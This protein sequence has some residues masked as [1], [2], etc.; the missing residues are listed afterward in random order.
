MIKGIPEFA[1]MCN[2]GGG[3][4][5]DQ[6]ARHLNVIGVQEAVRDPEMK[7]AH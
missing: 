2:I 3:I 4:V 7:I 5:R 1:T 6:V